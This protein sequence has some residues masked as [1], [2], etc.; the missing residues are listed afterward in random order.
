LART[1]AELAAWQD[2]VAEW[3]ELQ[4]AD[5]QEAEAALIPTGLMRPPG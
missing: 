3:A 1:Y 5:R 2:I 4:G